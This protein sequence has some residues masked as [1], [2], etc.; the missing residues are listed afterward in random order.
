M[1][2]NTLHPVDGITADTLRHVLSPTQY[3]YYTDYI[4]KG[5]KLADISIEYDVAISTV[6]VTIKRARQRILKYCG[7]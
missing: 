1:I 4:Y 5:K 7:F 2:K 3:R 6:C